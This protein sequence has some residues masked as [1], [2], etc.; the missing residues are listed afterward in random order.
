MSNI[1]LWAFSTALPDDQLFHRWREGLWVLLRGGLGM[2]WGGELVD[3]VEGE[4]RS[5]PDNGSHGDDFG[6]I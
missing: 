2:G 3:L 4:F 6:H 5:D 1:H